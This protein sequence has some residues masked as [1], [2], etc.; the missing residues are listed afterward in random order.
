MFSKVIDYK[1]IFS[2]TQTIGNVIVT[3][4]TLEN[5]KHEDLGVLFVYRSRGEYMKKNTTLR[6]RIK[7]G[8]KRNNRFLRRKELQFQSS[9]VPIEITFSYLFPLRF[10]I[11][12]TFT[13]AQR[14]GRQRTPGTD[15][16][17]NSINVFPILLF[18]PSTCTPP[19]LPAC[20]I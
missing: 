9:T 3:K 20:I 11:I 15:H 18:L 7:G 5:N 6:K 13:N 4:K 14:Q 16:T 12:E 10:F 1:S 2:Q 17:A 19:N 8:K